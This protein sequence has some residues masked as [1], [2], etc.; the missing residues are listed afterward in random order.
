M[1]SYY[2][3][4]CDQTKG[5]KEGLCEVYDQ[6]KH[7]D[8]KQFIYIKRLDKK[9][10]P[11][12]PIL[13][14]PKPSNEYPVVTKLEVL[15]D[16]PFEAIEEI[17]EEPVFFYEKEELLFSRRALIRRGEIAPDRIACYVYGNLEQTLSSVAEV[18]EEY[19]LPLASV[20]KSLA[21]TKDIK[22]YAFR[23]YPGHLSPAAEIDLKGVVAEVDNIKFFNQSDIANYCGVSRQAVSISRKRNSKRINGKEVF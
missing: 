4:H 8:S 3:R 22:Q 16:E 11:A 1:W 12:S 13:P 6:V 14:Y 10:T 20:K 7:F 18:V 21:G 19:Q 2:K 15:K 23:W 5:F 9:L 17:K